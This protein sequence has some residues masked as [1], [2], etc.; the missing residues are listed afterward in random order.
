MTATRGG[1][2]TL[3]PLWFGEE[4]PSE[5]HISETASWLFELFPRSVFSIEGI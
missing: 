1:V 3:T 4:G 5:T 2:Q